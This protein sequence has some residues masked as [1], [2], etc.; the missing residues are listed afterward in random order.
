[1]DIKLYDV[2]PAEYSFTIYPDGSKY[3][4]LT[5]G[6]TINIYT[7]NTT[8]GEIMTLFQAG[9]FEVDIFAQMKIY[10]KTGFISLKNPSAS[11]AV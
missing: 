9:S 1:M 5:N 7:G 4:F 6:N 8:N 3:V 10:N 2:R 11:G